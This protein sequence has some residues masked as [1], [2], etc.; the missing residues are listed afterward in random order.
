MKIELDYYTLFE[1]YDWLEEFLGSEE[2]LTAV[3]EGL[4]NADEAR[5][6]L[7]TQDVYGD[8]IPEMS[9]EAWW[10]EGN[11]GV[12]AV[13]HLELVGFEAEKVLDFLLVEYGLD[14]DEVETFESVARMV[15]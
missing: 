2:A 8:Y 10:L 9:V 11:G 5:E 4:D 15:N 14:V 7:L 6:S 12:E 3:V 13:Q 1:K